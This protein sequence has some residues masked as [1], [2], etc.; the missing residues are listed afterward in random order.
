[1]A[2]APGRTTEAPPAPV[3]RCCAVARF[4]ATSPRATCPEALHVVL[5]SPLLPPRL[6]AREPLNPPSDV[7]D[8][9]RLLGRRRVSTW[10][11]AARPSRPSKRYRPP[12]SRL[13]HGASTWP[14]PA[15]DR[16]SVERTTTCPWKIER[17][18]R[19]AVELSER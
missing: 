19:A 10:S 17:Y 13:G 16:S 1:M 9:D 15:E 2:C 12:S 14:Q 8:S 7:P 11:S 18:D 4:C 6:D 3:E 5:P